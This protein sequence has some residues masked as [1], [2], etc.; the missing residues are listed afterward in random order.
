[1]IQIY[2]WRKPCYDI[3]CLAAFFAE[4][5][6]VEQVFG[7]AVLRGSHAPQVGHP[8]R[9]FFDGL[10]LLVQE[11]RLDEIAQLE[12]DINEL[13]RKCWISL[14]TR[15]HHHQNIIWYQVR[16][17]L[18]SRLNHYKSYVWVVVIR[19]HPVQVQQGL[20][21]ALLKFQGAFKGLGSTAP[22]ISLWFL[23]QKVG[24]E[25]KSSLKTSKHG[26]RPAL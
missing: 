4:G 11:M 1:M 3:S 17:R 21:H 26:Q 5:V 18:S 23:Q 14:G 25:N 24:Q 9:Q 10:H 8:V 6:F 2:T 16:N 20:V 19:A 12:P 22:L 13:E 15:S 7:H